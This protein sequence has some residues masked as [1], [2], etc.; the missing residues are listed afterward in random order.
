MDALV[1]H[2]DCLLYI[3]V[4]H[5]DFGSGRRGWTLPALGP[6]VIVELVLG[7]FEH[8]MSAFI[9]VSR[10]VPACQDFEVKSDSK[11]CIDG[12]ESKVAWGVNG[13]RTSSGSEVSNRDLWDDLGGGGGMPG[14]RRGRLRCV[15][16]QG[17][18]GEMG[19]ESANE[20]AQECRLKNPGRI[21][22]LAERLLPFIALWQRAKPMVALAPDIFCTGSSPALVSARRA[23]H[24]FMDTLV[25]HIDCLL[26]ID[27]LPLD[28]GSGRRGWTLP[29]LR[30]RVILEL[31]YGNWEHML[32]SISKQA[33]S[34]WCRSRRNAELRALRIYIPQNMLKMHVAPGNGTLLPFRAA[35]GLKRLL[36]P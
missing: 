10:Y 26:D 12:V 25:V 36:G 2:I 17:H 28:F 16:V 33:E 9:R 1:V 21:K 35:F 22:Y 15:Y 34:T 13:W 20:L 18:I 11:Y 14:R 7:N 8:I 23:C 30:P 4:L 6:P 27:L 5:L 24:A 31:V 32:S 19:N 3:D 29:A